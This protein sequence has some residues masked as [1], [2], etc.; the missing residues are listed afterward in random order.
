MNRRATI[1]AGAL[2][3]TLATAAMGQAVDITG[4]VVRVDP[5]AQVIVLDNNQAVRVTPNT[6]LLVDN[7][8]VTLSTIQPGQPVLIRS[9]E[10][11]TVAPSAPPPTVATPGTV[12]TTPG[13]VATPGNTVVVQTPGAV[14]TIPSQTVYGRVTDVDKGEIKVKTDGGDF[15]VKVP[16]DVSAQLRKGDTVRLDMTFNPR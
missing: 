10:A 9:G 16:R 3:L 15:E 5:G 2:V 8:P 13:A 14:S 1:L 12:V 7:R 4:R 11:V 6:V